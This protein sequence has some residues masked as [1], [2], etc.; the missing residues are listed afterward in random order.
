MFIILINF[1]FT[2]ARTPEEFNVATG[3][4]IILHKPISAE[5]TGGFKADLLVLIE[6][7]QKKKCI[8][9][10]AAPVLLEKKKIRKT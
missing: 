1:V 2:R 8:Q 5:K 3:N 6:K 9:V 7:K 10:Y 4:V